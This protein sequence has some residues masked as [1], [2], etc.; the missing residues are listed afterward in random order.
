VA[1]GKGAGG[2]DGD[3]WQATRAA[4]ASRRARVM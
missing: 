2:D 4:L 3:G 1:V